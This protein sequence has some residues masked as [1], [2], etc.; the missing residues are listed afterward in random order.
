MKFD[1]METPIP[2][3]INDINH[4]SICI[5]QGRYVEKQF[6]ACIIATLKRWFIVAG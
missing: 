2:G 3:K 4:C 5:K 6:I 1:L